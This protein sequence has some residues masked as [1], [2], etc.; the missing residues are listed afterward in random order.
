[1]GHV[2]KYLDIIV[3]ALPL[4]NYL[5]LFTVFSYSVETT[6]G[7]RLC[8]YDFLPTCAELPGAAPAFADRAQHVSSSGPARSLA[9]PATPAHNTALSG[10]IPQASV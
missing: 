5:I 7:L 2:W 8:M 9:G 10:C 6:K 1:M 3:N 4:W